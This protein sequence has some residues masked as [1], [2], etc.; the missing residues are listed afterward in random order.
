[1]KDLF[2]TA[3]VS[4]HI[5]PLKGNSFTSCSLIMEKINRRKLKLTGEPVF[6]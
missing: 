5:L 4:L 3:N 1:M 6:K 2:S